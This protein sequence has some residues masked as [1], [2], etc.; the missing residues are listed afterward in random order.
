MNNMKILITLFVLISSYS[1]FAQKIKFKIDNQK[2]TTVHL[3]RYF[4]KGLYYADTT[5][6][7]N[8]IIEFNGSKQKPGILALFLPGQ[9]MLEFVYND[10]DIFIESSYPDLMGTA[11]VKK[12]AENSVFIPYVKFMNDNQRK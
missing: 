2:D 7:K 8:G 12:S 5:E 10:E 6:A 1:L 11:K 3:I 9:K 4:G